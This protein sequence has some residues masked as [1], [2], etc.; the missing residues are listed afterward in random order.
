MS[1]L[2]AYLVFTVVCAVVAGVWVERYAVLDPHVP[3]EIHDEC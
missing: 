3:T 2:V 1:V